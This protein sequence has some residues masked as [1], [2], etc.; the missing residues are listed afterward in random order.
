MVISQ[1]LFLC[2]NELTEKHKSKCP[3]CSDGIVTPMFPDHKEYW[4]FA[5]DKCDFE[6]HFDKILRV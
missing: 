1:D 6:V 4:D 2:K 5:C 3:K